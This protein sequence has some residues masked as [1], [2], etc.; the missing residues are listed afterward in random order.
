MKKLA[1]IE[2]VGVIEAMAQEAETIFEHELAIA[3]GC[4]AGL[5]EVRR[6]GNARS[7]FTRRCPR[8]A[9]LRKS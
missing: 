7:I 2:D 1:K 3:S 5:R 9:L 6:T 8:V 4:A